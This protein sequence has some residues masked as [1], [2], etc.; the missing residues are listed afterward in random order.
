MTSRRMFFTETYQG[1]WEKYCQVPDAISYRV[2]N[3]MASGKFLPHQW[4]PL[5]DFSTGWPLLNSLL[6]LELKGH[7][8]FLT[9]K[10]F[11]EGTGGIKFDSRVG[12]GVPAPE[13]PCRPFQKLR[14][15]LTRANLEGQVKIP[16]GF[17]IPSKKRGGVKFDSPSQVPLL[18]EFL[19]EG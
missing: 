8:S 1:I 3:K 17:K 5:H 13:P 14:D 2:A 6:T 10:P 18:N 9:R 19:P 15:L 12:G 16:R 4:K 11:K 7:T